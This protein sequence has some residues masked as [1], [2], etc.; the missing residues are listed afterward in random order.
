MT[1]TAS[2]PHSNRSTTS[3]LVGLVLLFL[4]LVPGT[5]HAQLSLAN[6]G[7]WPW[8]QD[9]QPRFGSAV[10]AG[11]FDGDGYD[12]MAISAPSADLAGFANSGLIRLQRTTGDGGSVLV[13]GLDYC[14]DETDRGDQYFFGGAMV[15]GDFD[16]DGDDDLAIGIPGAI[17]GGVLDGGAVCVVNGGEG[18]L[19]E[20]SRARFSQVELGSSPEPGDGFGAVLAAGDL[21]ADGYQDLAIGS[22]N[23]SVNL[24]GGDVLGAGA[25]HVLFGGPTGL[26]V[27]DAE[28]IYRRSNGNGWQPATDEHFGSSL[29]IGEF[30]LADGALDLMIGA[31]GEHP[32]AVG[33][34]IT[35]YYGEAGGTLAGFSI[36]MHVGNGFFD[37]L[38][39][40]ES[41][42]GFGFS[43]APG[44]FDGDGE[45]DLAVGIPGD[46]DFGPEQQAGAVMILYND[47]MLL[48]DEGEQ[49]FSEQVFGGGVNAFDRFGQVLAAGDF[50]RDGRDDLAMGAPL[51]NSLG[52]INAGEVTV[53]YGAPTGLQVSGFQIANM[54]FFAT[55]EPN[56]EFGA[57]L[58]TGR[59]YERFGGDDLLIGVPGRLFDD[60]G[61]NWPNSGAVVILQSAVTQSAGFETGD[62]SEWSAVSP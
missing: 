23:E 59:F 49:V 42:D 1:L 13:D 55:V 30:A 7:I 14:L 10:A 60:G 6:S 62:L 41:G 38:G 20:A 52:T 11:D 9:G 3:G 61:E 17:S 4:L 15:F 51:D 31:P 48:S 37:L 43:M 8:G 45:T 19:L 36:P 18:T 24:G 40:P 53:I 25:V 57:A 26:S 34:N 16:G 50:D 58:A 27:V 5:A 47:G 21:N 54:F 32:N 22:P 12:D 56:D 35:L 28:Q 44:D 2:S 46:S 29:A 33:G 39:T